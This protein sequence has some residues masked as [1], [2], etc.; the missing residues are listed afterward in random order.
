[1]TRLMFFT[2]GTSLFH[3]ASWEPTNDLLADAPSYRELVHEERKTSPEARAVCRRARLELEDALTEAN[4]ARWAGYLPAVLLRDGRHAADSVLRFSA[5]LATLLR[6]VEQENE[7]RSA[8][9][10]LQNYAHLFVLTDPTAPPRDATRRSWVAAVHLTAYLDAIAGGSAAELSPVPG[11]ASLDRE[12]L[13]SADSGLP[14]LSRRIGDL[15]RDRDAEFVDVVI[16]GGYKIYGLVLA[17]LLGREPLA[18][19]AARLI[20]GHESGGNLLIVRDAEISYDGKSVSPSAF[21]PR[22]GLT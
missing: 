2:V 17:R 5:E 12:I 7:G 16:T 8:R 10:F 11:L 13:F 3:S 15:K 22:P 20:Y 14:L 18:H 4:A 9:R 19:A 6:L 1:M 21:L